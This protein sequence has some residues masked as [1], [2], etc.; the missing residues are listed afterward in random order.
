MSDDVEIHHPI[1]GKTLRVPGH[2]FPRL[3]AKGWERVDARREPDTEA[4]NVALDRKAELQA[5]LYA[6]GVKWDRRWGEKR[7]AAE[8]AK[9]G[10]GQ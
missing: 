9:L 6:A 1:R 10:E 5:T 7:L 2:L 3:A 8:V 4:L